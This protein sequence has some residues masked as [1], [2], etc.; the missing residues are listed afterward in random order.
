MTP[1]L[2]DKS[3]YNKFF[4]ARAI[5]NSMFR[6]SHCL[7]YLLLLVSYGLSLNTWAEDIPRKSSEIDRYEDKAIAIHL[8]NRTPDQLKA[9]YI[10]RQFNKASINEILNTCF[11]TPIIH[12]FSQDILWLDLDEWRFSSNGKSFNR[13]R[14]D[15][16]PERWKKAKLPQ[17]QQSTF[18]WTLL[19]EARDLHPEESVGGSFVIPYQASPFTLTM[20]FPV[21]ADK[22]S[23]VKTVTF[24]GV[25]CLR[26]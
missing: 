14:R 19:P 16:W 10:A 12:N 8:I 20:N 13:L 9:F 11:V 7:I 21:G 23:S 17:A 25:Q 2:Q 24:E 15:Y 22:Q 1:I 5:L 26:N 18:G 6:Y 3:I 4:P